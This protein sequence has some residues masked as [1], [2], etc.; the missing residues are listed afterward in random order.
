MTAITNQDEFED[1]CL[2]KLGAPVI[3]IN[4]DQE[5]VHDAVQDALYKFW[6]YHRDG[7][8]DA[9]YLYQV[10]AADVT[11][12]WIP[13]PPHID[14]VTEVI[15]GPAIDSIGQWSTPQWQMAQAMLAPKAALV[16][17]RLTDYVTMQQRLSDLN[18]VLKKTKVFTFKKW[19]RKIYCQF[20]M[21]VGEVLAFQCY[22]NID[23]REPGCEEAW[24]DMWLK[25]YATALIKRRWAEVLKK[26]RGIRLPGG[27]ELDGD[28]MFNEA[29]DEIE[30]LE[31][32]LETGHQDPI[33]FFFG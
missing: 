28:T 5:Q 18:S 15:A 6:E 31:E 33:N 30:K 10:Q 21:E 24:N 17:I 27:I 1:Y 3:Q 9:Y 8:Q 20:P 2:R 11:N 26:A 4:L 14:D 16:A 19:Q 7:S 23:P 12:G 22:E 29:L 25:A 13:T 32:K